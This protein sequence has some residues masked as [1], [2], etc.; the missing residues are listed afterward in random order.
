MGNIQD[1]LAQDLSGGQKRKLTFGIAILGDPQV[2]R[3]EVTSETKRRVVRLW[4]AITIN[5]QLINVRELFR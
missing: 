4:C 2:G 1:A 5:L 3:P